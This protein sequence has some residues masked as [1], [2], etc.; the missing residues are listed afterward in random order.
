L[1]LWSVEVA[2]TSLED[3]LN[4][5]AEN[6]ASGGGVAAAAAAAAAFLVSAAKVC[7]THPLAAAAAAWM[8]IKKTLAE[9]WRGKSWDFQIYMQ[10]DLFMLILVLIKNYVY[11]LTSFLKNYNHVNKRYLLEF[12][13]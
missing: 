2:I 7:R 11:K 10:I 5:T 3:T 12:S 4:S 6:F 8:L 13:F 9:H 1:C